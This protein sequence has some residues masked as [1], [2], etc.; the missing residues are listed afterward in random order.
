MSF[1]VNV[2]ELF[3]LDVAEARIYYESISIHVADHF[4]EAFD[5]A[6]QKLIQNPEAY[7]NLPKN[8]RRIPINGFPYQII[9]TFKDQVIFIWCLHHAVS[10]KRSWI[11]RRKI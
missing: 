11:K 9:Y 4:D 1:A 5:R 6:Y 2:H 10:N 7:F 8:I 3:W